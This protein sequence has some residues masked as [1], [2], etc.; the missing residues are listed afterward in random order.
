M[1]NILHA[2]FGVSKV[3]NTLGG[4]ECTK[5]PIP[6]KNNTCEILY[7]LALCSEYSG[8][9]QDWISSHNPISIV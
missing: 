4:V 6:S 5:G 7:D 9:M 3:V 1:A 8:I 2:H